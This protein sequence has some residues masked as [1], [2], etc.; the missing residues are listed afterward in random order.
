MLDV[1]Q[2]VQ[3]LLALTTSPNIDEARNAA[4]AAVRLIRQHGL[5]ITSPA[6]H[7][8]TSFPAPTFRARSRKNGNSGWRRIKSKYAGSCRWCKQTIEPNTTIYWS[9]DAGAYHCACYEDSQ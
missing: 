1:L 6:P 9:R 3:A 2:K 5:V 4:L 8:G 7:T